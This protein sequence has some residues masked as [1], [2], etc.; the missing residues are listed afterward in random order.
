[1]IPLSLNQDWWEKV[2]KC[3]AVWQV[4]C[5]GT[6]QPTQTKWVLLTLTIQIDFLRPLSVTKTN[7]PLDLTA[8]KT[9]TRQYILYSSSLNICLMA[10]LHFTQE[11]RGG[12]RNT[13]N[14]YFMFLSYV[15]ISLGLMRRRREEG[16]WICNILSTVCSTTQPPPTTCEGA[17]GVWCH[18]RGHR[19]MT[20]EGAKFGCYCYNNYT[21][22]W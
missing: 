18:G 9:N 3:A 11:L 7:L 5:C 13:R 15:D 8:D 20:Q 12:Q 14:L 16:S 1:M 6:T 22:V 19:V 21:P 10:I 2:Y 4:P 17:D